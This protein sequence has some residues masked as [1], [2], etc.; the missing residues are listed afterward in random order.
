MINDDQPNVLD[1]N[2]SMSPTKSTQMIVWIKADFL[3][4]INQIY[5]NIWRF[6]GRAQRSSR[7]FSANGLFLSTN[8][9]GAV[10]LEIWSVSLKDFA[11]FFFHLFFVSSNNEIT[12]N[13][14]ISDMKKF[15][16][17]I[18][19]FLLLIVPF[20]V[21]VVLMA[22]YTGGEMIQERVQMNASFIQMPKINL[23]Q[24]IQSIF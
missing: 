7:W 20:F 6:W 18:S 2:M 13:I 5:I 11:S 10:R 9:Q 21:A 8:R 23:F 22:L 17:Q 15:T 19:P 1:C 4:N 12:Y 16:N 24:V 3:K 14:K